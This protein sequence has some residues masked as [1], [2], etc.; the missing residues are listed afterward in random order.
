MGDCELLNLGK[1]VESIPYWGKVRF[2]DKLRSLRR[3]VLTEEVALS[4]EVRRAVS[5]F[6][7]NLACFR[8]TD[9]ALAPDIVKGDVAYIDCADGLIKNGDIY[10][11]NNQGHLVLRRVY[12][13]GT[14]E[15][16]LASVDQE[17]YPLE[18][19]ERSEFSNVVVLGR[20]CLTQRTKSW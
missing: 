19:C 4:E 7:A 9:D 2:V 17:R 6:P 16:V 8:V 13:K 20:L 5:C 18:R 11:V 10:A 12:K 3:G 15:I 1:R 14:D